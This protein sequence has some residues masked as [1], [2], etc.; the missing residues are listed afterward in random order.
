MIVLVGVLHCFIRNALEFHRLSLYTLHMLSWYGCSDFSTLRILAARITSSMFDLPCQLFLCT[1][2]SNQAT[3]LLG[4]VTLSLHLLKGSPVSF[5]GFC[6]R[7]ERSSLL[8]MGEKVGE[9][10]RGL[11]QNGKYEIQHGSHQFSPKKG[12]NK[13]EFFFPLPLVD[14]YLVSDCRLVKVMTMPVY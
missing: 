8:W 2:Y 14:G 12:T 11:E 5:R 4:P 3:L 1:G 10:N 7:I 13:S 9:S 6:R